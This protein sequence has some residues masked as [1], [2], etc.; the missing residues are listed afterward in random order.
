MH[1]DCAPPNSPAS[2][3]VG[4]IRCGRESL[5]TKDGID[6]EKRRVGR[7]RVLER[8]RQKFWRDMFH[9]SRKNSYCVLLFYAQNVNALC[10]GGF[11]HRKVIGRIVG[12]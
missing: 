12:Q 1:T 8:A 5:S 9:C 4:D 3:I 11:A 10:R 6:N 2:Y 7:C